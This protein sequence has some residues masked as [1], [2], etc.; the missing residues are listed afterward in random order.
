MVLEVHH[1]CSFAPE[2]PITDFPWR[3]RRPRE[4]ETGEPCDVVL[5]GDFG[6]TIL[7]AHHRHQVLAGYLDGTWYPAPEHRCAGA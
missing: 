5:K 7:V 4:A 3:R 2:N 1:G 6:V